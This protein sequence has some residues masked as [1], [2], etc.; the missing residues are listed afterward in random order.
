MS[1][2]V[3]LVRSIYPAWERGDFSSTDWADADIEFGFAD[4]PEPQRWKGIDG[5]TEGWLAFM[6]TWADFRAVPT[7]YIEVDEHR[8]LVFVRFRGH[9]KASGIELR[10]MEEKN[11][12]L[13]EF[14]DGRVAQLLLY[15]DRGRALA[16]LGLT[17]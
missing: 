5:M 7:E 11:A 15:W 9:A 16:D 8:V 10:E 13:A 3:D 6:R 1:E 4:G 12:M 2:N 14:R 17:E